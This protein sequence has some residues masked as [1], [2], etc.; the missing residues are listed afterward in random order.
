MRQSYG[1]LKQDKELL[2]FPLVSGFFI[3]LAVISFFVPLFFFK[4]LKD[5]PWD[6]LL[7]FA[8]YFVTYFI[9]IFFNAALVGAANIRL[10]G[11]DPK[12]GDGLRIAFENLG[13]IAVWAVI[14]ATVGLILNALSGKNKGG[15]LGK[16]TV[17]LLGGAWSLLTF[18][19]V[20]VMIIEKI[21]PIDAI[22]RSTS[23]VRESFGEA[24][25][26][27]LGLGAITL[28]GIVFALLLGVLTFFLTAALG[29]I[30]LVLAAVVFVVL[31][32]SVTIVSLALNAIF[33][34]AL[35]HYA[36]TGEVPKNWNIEELV[37][38]ARNKTA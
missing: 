26:G 4:G 25:I 13:R 9:V 24:I 8:F 14:A 11:G 35:Y 23:I 5:S 31:A 6:Y 27:Q 12:L 33:V 36:A 19:V 2:V 29:S 28:C 15:L 16:I 37:E 18:F 17:A 10:N 20:P 30:A 3:L 21:G 32:A 22:K 1:V 34:T 7:M 38:S